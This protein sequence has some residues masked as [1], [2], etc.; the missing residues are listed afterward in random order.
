VDIGIYVKL[1]MDLESSYIGLRHHPALHGMNGS[2]MT[3]RHSSDPDDALA[4]D[5]VLGV[6]RAPDQALAER[7]SET[8]PAFAARVAAHRTRLFPA[9][10]S[11]SAAP[12]AEKRPRALVWAN[13]K[14]RL[15]D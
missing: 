6:L 13:I 7:R 3:D 8:E 4:L 14:A 12:P 5:L 11:S 9:G 2:P 1:D 10:D 15:P